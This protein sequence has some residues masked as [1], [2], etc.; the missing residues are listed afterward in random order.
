[1]NCQLQK[2]DESKCM[3]NAM[4][5]SPYCYQHNPSVLPHEKRLAQ[6][7]G[8]KAN[9]IVLKEP[10]PAFRIQKCNDVVELLVTTINEMRS[11]KID[12]KVANCIG[13][14]SGHLMRAFEMANLE[15]R[16]DEIEQIITKNGAL[17][18]S[19]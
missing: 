6:S 13:V 18:K 8:G 19:I 11:G 7:R 4:S 12:A 2:K 3:A 15:E 16:V 14:L 9:R 10:L 5:G 1:M 17:K